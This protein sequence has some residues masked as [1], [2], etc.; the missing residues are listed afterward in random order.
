MSRAHITVPPEALEK[1]QRL[2]EDG[3]MLQAYEASKA[4]GP[5]SHWS[6][7]EARMLAGRLAGN[8]GGYRLGSALHF[9]AWRHDKPN[10]DLAAYHG[11]NLLHRRGPLVALEFLERCGEPGTDCPVDAAMHFFTL[12]ASI[13]ASL[14]DFTG[15]REFMAR[16]HNAAPDH[17][18][19][20]TCESHLLEQEDHYDAALELA[21]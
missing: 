19:V 10:F 17:A 9:L 14:R 4:F 1:I 21:R 13:A 7:S 12:R 18:W 11:Y 8:L 20:L 15:A 5:L 16:A 6:G 3:Q 2:Y